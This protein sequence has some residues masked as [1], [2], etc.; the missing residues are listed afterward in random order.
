MSI[1]AQRISILFVDDETHVLEGLR[2]MLRGLRDEWDMV[3]TDSGNAAVALLGARGFDVVVTDLRLPGRDGVELLATVKALHPRAVRLVLSGHTDAPSML[4][5]A[6][7]AQQY[8]AKPCDA[9]LLKATIARALAL[10]SLLHDERLVQLVGRIGTLPSMPSAYQELMACLGSPRP[11]LAD[12]G[13]IVARDPAMSVKVL[14]LVNSAYFGLRQPVTAVGRAV[15][16]LGMESLM[17][18][19]LGHGLFAECK[20]CRIPGFSFERL[21]DRSL[22]VAMTARQLARHEALDPRGQDDAFLAGMLHDLGTLLLA[23]ELPDQYALVA[24]RRE[25]AAP[26]R[27]AAE[28]AVFSATHAEVGA[29][30]LGLWGLPNPVVEAVAFH[31]EPCRGPTPGLSLAGIVHVAQAL[32]GDPD[33]ATV[34][35]IWVDSLCR[36]DPWATWRLAAAGT[37]PPD[38]VNHAVTGC[39]T[40]ADSMGGVGV[41]RGMQA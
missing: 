40:D 9:D 25:P 15:S 18:L 28:L 7:V 5:A 29:Y 41:A 20:P 2:R 3:F 26:G 30:L 14:Q 31:E 17:A 11:S 35:P 39:T 8:L 37:G 12:A 4:R 10:R 34:D 6:G 21:W 24:N 32:A 27:A 13:R 1:P 16:Y 23:A 36:S 22:A 33:T 19:A 38:S